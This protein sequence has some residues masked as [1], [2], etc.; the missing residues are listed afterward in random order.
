[1]TNEKYRNY[2]GGIKMNFNKCERCGCFFASAD[3]VCPKCVSKDLYE[4][5]T[6]KNYLEEV[7]TLSSISHICSQTGLSE[8]NIYRFLKS[9]DFKKYIEPKNK[10]NGNISL[11]L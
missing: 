3:S 5:S 9:N 2:I 6:L 10:V 8:K 7:D 4:M 11:E 1:M